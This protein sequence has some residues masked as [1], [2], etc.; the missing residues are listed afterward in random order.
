M[1]SSL[2]SQQQQQQLQRGASGEARMEPSSNSSSYKRP[3]SF[4]RFMETDQ[5]NNNNELITLNATI[6]ANDLQ[7]QIDSSHDQPI[8]MEDQPP[9]VQDEE[10]VKEEELDGNNIHTVI[11]KKLQQSRTEAASVSHAFLEQQQSYAAAYS[12]SNA[13]SV[14]A[15][16]P[17]QPANSY[18]QLRSG[19]AFEYVSVCEFTLVYWL[20]TWFFELVW[21]FVFYYLT[22]ISFWLWRRFISFCL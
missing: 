18:H 5:N 7:Q 2:T 8:V 21:M 1:P 17:T 15:L 20:P 22:Y 4:R 12:I 19:K 10:L 9:L 14:S 13:S 3:H 11:P 6:A 16:D